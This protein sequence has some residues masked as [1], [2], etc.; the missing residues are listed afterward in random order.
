MKTIFTL[1]KEI[2]QIIISDKFI[3]LLSFFF[4]IMLLDTIYYINQ[5]TIND[6]INVILSF[7]ILP[8]LMVLNLIAQ[9]R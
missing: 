9:K 3:T 5:I 1:T 7:M 8:V 4:I 6:F 2:Y